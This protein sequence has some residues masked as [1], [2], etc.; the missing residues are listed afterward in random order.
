[1]H[2]K[3]WRAHGFVSTVQGVP[4]LARKT[5]R[6][7]LCSY[8]LRFESGSNN[9]SDYFVLHSRFFYDLYVREKANEGSNYFRRACTENLNHCAH[10]LQQLL[11]EYRENLCEIVRTENKPL[12]SASRYESDIVS[13]DATVAGK[14]TGI[15]TYVWRNEYTVTLQRKKKGVLTSSIISALVHEHFGHAGTTLLSATGFGS[16][17]MYIRKPHP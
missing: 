15:Y 17:A 11:H 7:P 8:D 9:A 5:A 13:I 16:L 3:E 12:P 10:K 6:S 2:S 4:K 1:M 14:R